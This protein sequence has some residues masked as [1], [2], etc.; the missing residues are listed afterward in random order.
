MSNVKLPKMLTQSRRIIIMSSQQN[1]PHIITEANSSRADF[2]FQ[3][4]SR[5]ME[6]SFLLQLMCKFMYIIQ[7]MYLIGAAQLKYRSCP[8]CSLKR[9]IFTQRRSTVLKHI[10]KRLK[11]WKSSDDCIEA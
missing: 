2:Q 11:I 4:Q 10:F 6:L 5:I 9:Q 3:C 7:C 1:V 8:L